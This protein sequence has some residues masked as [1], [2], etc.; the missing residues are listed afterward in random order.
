VKQVT[1]ITHLLEKRPSRQADDDA[2]AKTNR[3]RGRDDQAEGS[4][5]ALVERFRFGARQEE[6]GGHGVSL[7][8]AGGE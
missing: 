3:P 1:R 8:R 2:K 4:D 5:A 6:A 7:Q